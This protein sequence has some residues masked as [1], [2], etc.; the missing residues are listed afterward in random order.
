LCGFVLR[1]VGELASYMGV[2]VTTCEYMYY[3]PEQM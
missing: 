2:Q 3:A 1:V